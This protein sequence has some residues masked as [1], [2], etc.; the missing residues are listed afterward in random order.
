MRQKLLLVIPEKNKI[1]SFGEIKRAILKTGLMFRYK[2]LDNNLHPIKTVEIEN[3]FCKE[4]QK[5]V[6][7][8]AC[9]YENNSWRYILISENLKKE[10]TCC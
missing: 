4:D 1:N 10:E 7:I 6:K 3:F 9:M 5:L 8:F 2:F